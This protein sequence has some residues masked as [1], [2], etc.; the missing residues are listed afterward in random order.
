MTRKAC[1]SASCACG[2]VTLEA[3]GAPILGVVCYCE[4]CRLAGRQFRASARRTLG[5]HCGRHQLQ[6]LSQGPGEDH[7][8][9]GPSAGASSH[10][11]VRDPTRRG[12]LLQRADVP[13]LHQRTLADAISRPV[14]GRCP[15]ARNGCDGQGPT[16]RRRAPGWDSDLSDAPCEVHGQAT[17]CMECNGL[18]A[19]QGSLVIG[20]SSLSVWRWFSRLVQGNGEKIPCIVAKNHGVLPR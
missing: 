4:S 12:D 6:P 1:F 8:R 7:A 18:S 14:A 2:Q 5:S 13:G 3:I 15:A 19:A 11:G 16:R 20:A 17:G 10:G 9:R